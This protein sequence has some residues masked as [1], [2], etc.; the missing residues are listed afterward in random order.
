MGNVPQSEH[1][2]FSI[3]GPAWRNRRHPLTKPSPVKIRPI[4]L[5]GIETYYLFNIKSAFQRDKR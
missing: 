5:T 4:D 3:N 2:P 1:C